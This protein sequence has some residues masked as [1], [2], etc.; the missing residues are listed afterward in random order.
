MTFLGVLEL[1]LR[2]LNDRKKLLSLS[3]IPKPRF[4][5]IGFHYVAQEGLELEIFLFLPTECWDYRCVPPF[6][7]GHDFKKPA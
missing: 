3:H 7:E 5:E 4:F 2:V 6:L 1:N